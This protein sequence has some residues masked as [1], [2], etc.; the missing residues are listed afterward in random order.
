[1]FGLGR[2]RLGSC[3][4]SNRGSRSDRWACARSFR[5]AF[6]AIAAVD[7]LEAFQKSA[8]RAHLPSKGKGPLPPKI[9]GIEQIDIA[10]PSFQVIIKAKRLDVLHPSYLRFLENR[11]RQRFG[12]EGTPIRFILR[13]RERE[14]K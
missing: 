3:G 2:F 12:F 7:E 8:V 14:N 11:L 4:R 13:E 6:G 1:M 9:L 10:P 5:A